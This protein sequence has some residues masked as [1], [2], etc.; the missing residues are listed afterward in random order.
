MAMNVARG[1]GEQPGELVCTAQRMGD[2]C[3]VVMAA[4][5]LDV[6]TCKEFQRVVNE[7][8]STRPAQLIVDLSALTFVDSSGLGV[9]VVL[10]RE[11]RR[12]LDIVVRQEH[13]RRLLFITGLNTVFTLHESV[14]DA[15]R[16]AA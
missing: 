4:G 6:H 16:Q 7:A 9:L 5:E 1:E 15:R 13:L 12:P 14:A 10:Q 11:M 8:R 2:S 3:T